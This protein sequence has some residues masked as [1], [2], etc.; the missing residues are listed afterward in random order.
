[1][2]YR[3]GLSESLEEYARRMGMSRDKVRVTWRAQGLNRLTH[4]PQPLEYWVALG[5]N[6]SLVRVLPGACIPTSNGR[7]VV[8]VE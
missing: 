3:N 6:K 1:M 7:C 5:C 4:A 8:E 2:I